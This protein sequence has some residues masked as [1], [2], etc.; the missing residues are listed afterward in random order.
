MLPHTPVET[1]QRRGCEYY[2]FLI[3]RSLGR[4]TNGRANLVGHTMVARDRESKSAWLQT[5][6]LHWL[7]S[8]RFIIAQGRQT[9]SYTLQEL[10]ALRWADGEGGLIPANQHPQPK[11]ATELASHV[12]LIVCVRRLATGLVRST[13]VS[14][15][16]IRRIQVSISSAQDMNEEGGE[17]ER[18]SA[19]SSSATSQFHPPYHIRAV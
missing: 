17:G 14:V 9:G 15:R 10:M 4:T 5:E 19:C 3:H 2:S 11:C 18:M 12:A 1:G 13:L 6:I 7:N 8:F 16:E